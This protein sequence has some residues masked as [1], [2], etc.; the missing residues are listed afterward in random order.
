MMILIR[1][2]RSLPRKDGVESAKCYI[3]FFSSFTSVLGRFFHGSGSDPKHCIFGKAGND[4]AE[5]F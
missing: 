5:N 3:Q 4:L 2:W 1:V